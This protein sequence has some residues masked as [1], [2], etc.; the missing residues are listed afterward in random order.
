MYLAALIVSPMAVVCLQADRELIVAS[1]SRPSPS[2][3]LDSIIIAIRAAPDAP[4]SSRGGETRLKQRP[5]EEWGGP[6]VSFNTKYYP[7]PPIFKSLY[8]NLLKRIAPTDMWVQSPRL[9]HKVN[10]G[11]EGRGPR[12]PPQRAGIT[13][14]QERDHSSQRTQSEED[15]W[16]QAV[17][18][19]AMEGTAWCPNRPSAASPTWATPPRAAADSGNRGRQG[20][21]FVDG[22]RGISAV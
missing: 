8:S 2:V 21:V 22:Q 6:L 7:R 18:I 1:T 20:A 3:H 9:S 19:P 11:A 16:R 15:R 12:P 5:G 17:S 4:G 13:A 10:T 14:G